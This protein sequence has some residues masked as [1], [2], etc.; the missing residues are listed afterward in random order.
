MGDSMSKLQVETISQSNNTTGMTIDSS[1]RV[2][3]PTRPHALVVINA[4]ATGGYDT[5]A[6][7]AVIPFAAIVRETGSN[8]DT[9]NY[10][11]VC[12]VAG[13]YLVTCQLIIDSA[14][15]I[16]IALRLSGSDIH[17]F[18]VDSSRQIEF[19]TTVEATAS[20]Y[21]DFQQGS[22]G[23]RDINKAGTDASR[24]TAASF[25]LIG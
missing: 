23:D 4:T 2:L 15:N 5:V 6:N 17:R 12:P 18:F 20:Q 21:I 9:T 24:Y 7:N 1:G 16:D 14:A 8:Y 19:T 3:T 10:R 13:L 22:G 11:Y 25:T